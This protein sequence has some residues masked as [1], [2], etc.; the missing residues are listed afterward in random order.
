MREN[1]VKIFAV[2]DFCMHPVR[3]WFN[4]FDDGWHKE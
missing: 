2:K 1:C 4:A 3:L